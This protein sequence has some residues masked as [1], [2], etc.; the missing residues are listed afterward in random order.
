MDPGFCDQCGYRTCQCARPSQNRN[1]EE[2]G[3]GP[4]S[5]ENWQE[6]LLYSDENASVDPMDDWQTQ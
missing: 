3:D 5:A 4:H 1:E 6:K 2:V